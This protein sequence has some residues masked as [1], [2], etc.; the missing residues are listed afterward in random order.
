MKRILTILF[1]LFL[2][3]FL[4]ST[5]CITYSL[6]QREQENRTFQELEKIVE[7]SKATGKVIDSLDN[8]FDKIGDTDRVDILPQ[9]AEIFIQNTDFA[10]WLS[11]PNTQINYPVMST[12]KDPEYYL[13]RAFDGTSSQSG[14]PFIGVDG[15]VDS[16]CLIIYGHNMKNDTMFGMLDRYKSVEFW[17]DNKVFSFN[18]LQEEQ[19]YEVFAVVETRILYADE[20]GFRYYNCSGTLSEEEYQELTD[21]L[22]QQS[23]YDTGIIPNYGEQVLILSTCSYHTNNGRFIVAAR[24]VS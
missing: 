10:G 9:Y 4:I 7:E 12:P 8:D 16:D 24:I 15:S 1:Y 11:V 21:W 13:H 17:L 20:I 5:T 18:T 22:I 19:Q 23:I 14:T 6:I 3:L 2:L